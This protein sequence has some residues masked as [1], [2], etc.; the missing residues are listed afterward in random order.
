M[1]FSDM[2]RISTKDYIFSPRSKKLE[3]ISLSIDKQKYDIP[4]SPGINVIIGDNSIGNPY[5]YIK[6]QII[7]IY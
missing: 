5:Y 2:R 1:A 7:I 4:L 3:M 6:L